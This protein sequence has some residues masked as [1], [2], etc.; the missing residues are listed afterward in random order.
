M[1]QLKGSKVGL[2]REIEEGISE[3][4]GEIYQIICQSCEQQTQFYSIF[5]FFYFPLFYFE[6]IFIYLDI[7]K[8]DKT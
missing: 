7:G 6:F 1:I 5:L 4:K 2:D 3:A 8:E